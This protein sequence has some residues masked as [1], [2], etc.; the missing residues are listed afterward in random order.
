[1]GSLIIQFYITSMQELVLLT[2]PPA[3]GKTFWISSLVEEL[4]DHR[5]LVISPL[6]ALAYECREKWKD[7]VTVMTP[8]EW[9]GKKCRSE[10]VIFDEFHLYFYWGD[11]FRP[12]MW[13]VF[14]ELSENAGLT[15][16]L[17]ATFSEA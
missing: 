17:T 11:T 3:S 7:T 13:E 8:E 4:K 15:I 10:V 5:I 2:S 9:T 6:R 14:F 1:M 12:H 16:L